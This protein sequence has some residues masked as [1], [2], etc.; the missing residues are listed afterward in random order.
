[1]NVSTHKTQ[2]ALLYSLEGTHTSETVNPTSYTH[3]HMHSRVNTCNHLVNHKYTKYIHKHNT[4]MNK[5]N[6]LA[7]HSLYIARMNTHKTMKAT[8]KT[9]IFSL[10]SVCSLRAS[11]SHLQR[12]KPSGFRGVVRQERWSPWPWSRGHQAG[13]SGSR[14]LQQVRRRSACP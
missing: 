12:P 6:K 3:Q 8:S 4:N 7:S 5:L 11:G 9:F 1:M 2:C 10:F 13:R 14:R